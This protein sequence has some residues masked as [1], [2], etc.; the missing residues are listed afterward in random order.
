MVF[1]N[2]AALWAYQD[3]GA[4][5]RAAGFYRYHLIVQLGKEVFFI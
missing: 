4:A 2:K 3:T 5:S 1:K